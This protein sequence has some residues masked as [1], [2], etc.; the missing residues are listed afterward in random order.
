MPTLRGRMDHRSSPLTGPLMPQQHKTEHKTTTK[1]QIPKFN[2]EVLPKSKA[3]FLL[4]A[5]N[6][7]A[8]SLQAHSAKQP[9]RHAAR[10]F[11]EQTRGL[12]HRSD[13]KK[14]SPVTKTPELKSRSPGGAS[15]PS[16]A[17]PRP[18]R[19]S[20]LLP[21][22]WAPAWGRLAFPAP[23]CALPRG[24]AARGSASS[25]RRAGV[26]YTAGRSL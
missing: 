9:T 1:Q 4:S 16:R 18:E 13:E 12:T 21:R 11:R 8:P 22:S 24:R 23:H 6:G 25:R 14:R 15:P 3:T 19:A 7:E 5:A 20:R 26:I 17:G 10:A 2:R